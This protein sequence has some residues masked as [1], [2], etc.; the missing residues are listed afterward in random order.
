MPAPENI[1][2]LI[3]QQHDLVALCNLIDSQEQMAV[4]T[5]FVRTNTFAPR[6][7]LLQL[8]ISQIGVGA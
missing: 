2:L 6:L 8:G 5:E 1:P 3:E 7:G 4:D